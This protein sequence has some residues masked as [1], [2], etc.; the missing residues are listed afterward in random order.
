[1]KFKEF[2]W[3]GFLFE[4]PEE[5]RFTSEGGNAEKGYLRLEAEDFFFEA[6]WEPF[7]PKKTKPISE[8]AEAFVKQ[9]EKSKKLKVTILRKDSALVSKHNALYISLKSEA[10]ERIY[11]WYCDESKRFVIFRFVFKTFDEVGKQIIKQTLDT[12]RCHTE[13][14]N[15]WSVLDLRFELPTA[16]LLAD[17]KIAVGRSHISFNERKVSAFAEKSRAILIEYFSMANLA[18]K[19]TYRDLDKWLEKNYLKDLKKRYHNISFKTEESRK[20]KRHEMKIKQGIT[21]KG[22]TTRKTSVYTN[23]TWY[24]SGSNR[25]YSITVSS[26]IARPL[27]FKRRIEKEDHKNLI[28]ELLSSFKCH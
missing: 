17:R 13:K 27:F 8:V 22:L 16:F 15:I 19:D 23:A 20:F 18:F 2:G 26:H 1:L 21:A 3:N 25:I 9:M 14:S 7:L 28:E 24:C 11:M 4:V 10:E 12:F 5:V 6:K